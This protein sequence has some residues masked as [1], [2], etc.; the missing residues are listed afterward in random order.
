MASGTECDPQYTVTYYSS[1][2]TAYDA[3]D[4]IQTLD[5]DRRLDEISQAKTQ[6]YISDD[7]CCHQLGN[8]EPLV[9]EKAIRRNG[10]LVWYGWVT[11]VDYGRNDVVVEARDA[12]WWLA[13]RAVHN[14]IIVTDTDL[15]DIF[16][17]VW[18]DAIAPD[19]I[20]ASVVTIASGV[21]ESREIKQS[22]NRYA[23]NVIKE[24]LDSGL[25]VTA[26]ANVVYAGFVIN[27]RPLELRLADVQG[28]VR[29]TK[30]GTKYANR[31]IMDAGDQAVGVYPPGP[32][33]RN[34]FYPLTET[35][36][37]DFQIGDEESAENRAKAR[38]EYSRIVPRLVRNQDSIV[39]NPN[40]TL[41]IRDLIP[42]SEMA[43]DTTGLCY[44]QKELFRLGKLDVNVKA[45]VETI[46]LG[47][48]PSGPN[49]GL[50]DSGEVIE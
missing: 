39:L 10:E 1:G 5:W 31:V 11:R 40:T 42:G 48:Q 27:S 8:L 24:M 29:V 49:G 50:E 7:S 14:D 41:D 2:G 35:I 36:L 12:L 33:R 46:Q 26:I 47:L 37:K 20:N 43:V 25:D 17:L 16:Q 38:Y 23:W 3:P 19:E 32:P 6:Y 18:D 4:N 21:R 30:D 22:E 15:S 44:S 13:R 9:T 28:D 34:E 45:G